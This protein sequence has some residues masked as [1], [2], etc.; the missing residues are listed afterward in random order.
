VYGFDL[1]N[2][3]YDYEPPVAED[4]PIERAR[5]ALSRPAK[6]VSPSAPTPQAKP[7]TAT[8]A[9][10]IKLDKRYAGKVD[11]GATYEKINGN[12]KRR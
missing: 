4:Q 10:L 1:E 5:T 3:G 8:G 2:A 6:P 11:P 12:W 7:T 9:D